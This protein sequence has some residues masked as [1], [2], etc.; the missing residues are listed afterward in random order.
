ME[1]YE[2]NL[3]KKQKK[4]NKLPIHGPNQDPD[5]QN[6]RQFIHFSQR[7]WSTPTWEKAVF[8]VIG[9]FGLQLASTLVYY[10]LQATTFYDPENGRTLQGNALS[11]FLTYGLI[12]IAFFLRIFLDGR[13]TYAKIFKDFR[14][15][16]PYVYGAIGFAA[17]YLVNVVFNLLYS[18][19]VPSFGAN[20][21]QNSIEARRKA[22]PF[23]TITAVVIFAPFCEERTYRVGLLDLCGKRKRIAGLIISALLFGLIHFD[24]TPG[25]LRNIAKAEGNIELFESY[26]IRMINEWLNLP[27]YISSGLILGLT[28]ISSGKMASSWISHALLNA[29]SSIQVRTIASQISA[30]P[31]IH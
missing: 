19:T 22:S 30:T 29:L 12:F 9:F 20:N 11:T 1:I 21:N 6:K 5:N 27:I 8:F 14:D 10:I 7:N 13:K 3:S 25:I 23:F 4:E 31:F 15:W 26:R 2:D 24:R 18:K 28:Y 17:L 16:K